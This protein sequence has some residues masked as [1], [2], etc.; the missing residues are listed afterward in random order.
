MVHTGTVVVLLVSAI[1]STLHE[2][3]PETHV[4]H[5]RV[6]LAL[7]TVVQ[8]RRGIYCIWIL[9]LVAGRG[10]SWRLFGSGEVSDSSA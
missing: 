2:I 6:R 5:S 9:E 10:F 8:I 7:G 1:A 4:Q 3:V